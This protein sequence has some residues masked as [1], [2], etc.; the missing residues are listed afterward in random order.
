MTETVT[1]DIDPTQPVIYGRFSLESYQAEQAA[2]QQRSVDLY[3]R[4]QRL[5]ELIVE[6][7]QVRDRHVELARE[8][9]EIGKALGQQHIETTDEVVK[10]ETDG[11]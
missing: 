5:N 11:T 7:N 3:A 1:P 9:R 2:E 4:L 10:A 8:L 6:F